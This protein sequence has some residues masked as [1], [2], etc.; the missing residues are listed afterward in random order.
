MSRFR[1]SLIITMVL[2]LPSIAQAQATSITYIE[3]FA[4]GTLVN[5]NIGEN[6][7]AV[8]G[9]P[10]STISR[11]P[12]VVANNPNNGGPQPGVVSVIGPAGHFPVIPSWVALALG[13]PSP[14]GAGVAPTSIPRI[15]ATD[16]WQSEFTF[17]IPPDPSGRQVMR[18]G[19]F[20]PFTT[21]PQGPPV[22]GCYVEFGGRGD[23]PDPFGG[24]FKYVCSDGG[25][26]LSQVSSGVVPDADFGV[27]YTFRMRRSV[28]SSFTMTITRVGNT[29][30]NLASARTVNAFASLNTRELVPAFSVSQGFG[31]D[32]PGIS[33][34][35]FFF[36]HDRIRR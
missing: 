31:D 27:F 24:A 23:G 13:D 26:H 11:G 16:V 17:A 1:L 36:K 32:A 21:T 6:G 8:Y 2:V 5:G 19:L 29:E 28:G 30:E 10:G 7:W 3:E 9:T 14:Q 18:V 34:D 15:L 4:G 12:I 33:A 20:L 35:Y 25:L 22:D